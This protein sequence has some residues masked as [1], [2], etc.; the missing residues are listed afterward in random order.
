MSQL[1]VQLQESIREAEQIRRIKHH[2]I[3]LEERLASEV[4]AL[5]VMDQTLAKEQRDVEMLEREGMTTLFRK[6]LG[7]REE[8]LEK[9]REEYLRASLRYN[10]LYKS[11]ELIRYEL[12]LLDGKTQHLEAVERR[13]EV[14]I[15]ERGEELR[16][17]DPV[18]GKAIEDIH[19][20]TDRLHQYSV[21]YVE[22]IAAGEKA[23]ELVQ[24]VEQYLREAQQ[25]GQ[26]DM[27]G[28][29]RQPAGNMKH[30]AVD[31]ARETAHH[32]R[33]ALIHFGEELRDVYRD[34]EFL[35]DLQ[36]E[37]FGKFM[38]VFFDNLITDWLIQQKIKTSLHN[39]IRIRQDIEALISEAERDRAGIHGKLEALEVERR[40]LILTARGH[41]S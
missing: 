28:G 12:E 1:Y 4:N 16:R 8:K 9:E 34:R 11:V 40:Q 30:M 2:V 10:E 6:F 32:A 7:D 41:G 27:W 15:R 24:R 33:H 21:E 25:W 5:H 29:R 13:I 35:F 14:L 36:I 38:D 18:A 31:R 3:E 19:R 23:K 26:Q 39:V 37:A 20:Q 22:A 17:I